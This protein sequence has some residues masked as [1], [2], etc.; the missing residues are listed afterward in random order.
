[1]YFAN[2][3]P[4]QAW[5]NVIKENHL[6]GENAVHYRLPGPQ[7][8]MLER[9]LSVSSFP[10]YMLMDT[11]GNIVTMKAPRPQQKEQLVK[12]INQLL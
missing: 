8:S 3:S 1:M 6:S 10:T 9:R 2:S 11:E 12:E 7:Q 4:E 5:K